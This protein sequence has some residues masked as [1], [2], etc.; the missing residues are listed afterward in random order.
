M[1]NTPKANQAIITP[2]YWRVL[3]TVAGVVAL[4]PL[5]VLVGNFAANPSSNPFDETGYG[6]VI[7]AFFITVPTGGIIFAVGALVAVAIEWFV[8]LKRKSSR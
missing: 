4:S 8:G 2:R 3:S 7:W 5:A 1:T 6:A